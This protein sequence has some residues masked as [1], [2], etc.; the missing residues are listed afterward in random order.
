MAT[1]KDR[2][3]EMRFGYVRK[4]TQPKGGL[5]MCTN[6]VVKRSSCWMTMMEVFLFLSFTTAVLMLVPISVNAQSVE[7]V[8]KKVESA[9]LA[10]KWEKVAN[11][12]GSVEV[13]TASPVLRLIK[14]HACLAL[15]RNNESLCLFLSVLQGDSLQD[16][17]NLEK[18]QGWTQEFAG[19]NSNN[20]MGYYFR[21]DALARRQQWDE[22]L[23]SF[24]KALEIDPSNAMI[25]NARG[26]TYMAKGELALA[27]TDFDSVIKAEPNYADAHANLGFRLIRKKDAAEGAIE[28]FNNALKYS[29]DFALAYHGR[30]CVRFILNQTEAQADFDSALEKAPCAKLSFGANLFRI[31]AYMNGMNED[32]MLAEV[33]SENP[34]MPLSLHY[35]ESVGAL[36]TALST[37]RQSDIN[38]FCN[39]ANTLPA[40][41]VNKL[42]TDH[43][44]PYFD[45]HP[46]SCEHTL[47]QFTTVNT[48]NKGG[49]NVG[50]GAI[51][52][53]MDALKYGAIA[54]V[55]LGTGGNIWAGMGT[56]GVTG[57]AAEIT[58]GNLNTWKNNNL[59][60]S[61]TMCNSLSNYRQMNNVGGVDIDFSGT[62]RDEGKWPFEAFFG[63][64]YQVK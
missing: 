7:A 3:K 44:V 20:A 11:L 41:E 15:N 28:A 8:D 59:A 5:K 19:R 48:W 40:N 35:G 64:G 2:A 22:A 57:A 32:E 50:I 36:N 25:L 42:Y 33:T 39:I 54:G 13:T 30:G 9:V 37:Q 38:K 17:G 24:N 45:S 51:G 26:V 60:F 56:A 52:G 1:K 23:N 62:I 31:E 34:G 10:E 12:L 43:L 27:R 21:G 53:A 46:G 47:E 6:A 18:W 61:E 29:P 58:K 14:G 63:L 49:A 16:L 55:T 4:I